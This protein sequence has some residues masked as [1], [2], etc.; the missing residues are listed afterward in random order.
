MRNSTL[1][2]V[3]VAMLLI[4]I[5]NVSV[6]Q[7][8]TFGQGD[9]DAPV[10][11]PASSV[12]PGDF[13]GDGIGDLAIGIPREDVTQVASTV[14]D[15]GAVNV[16]YGATG[17]L[18]ATG[19]QLLYQNMPGSPPAGV[20]ELLDTCEIDDVLP[21]ALAVGNFDGDAFSDLAIGVPLED[22]AFADCGAV[23]VVYGGAGGLSA[24]DQQ[25]INQDTLDILDSC[26]LNDWFGDSLAAG[27]FNNDGF[28][29]LAVGIPQEDVIAGT[30]T[31]TDA[32][33]VQVIYGSAAGLT[34][35]DQFVNQNSV[36]SYSIL[37]ASQASDNFGGTLAAGDYNNDGFFDLAI[38]V[39]GEDVGGT[40]SLQTDCGAVNVIYGASTGLS[41]AGN[42]IL[43]QDSELPVGSGVIEL[44][45]S[46]GGPDPGCETGDFLGNSLAAGDFD[47]DGFADLCIGVR[48]EDVGDKPIINSAGAVNCVY[49]SASRFT[50]VDDQFWSQDSPGILEASEVGD[51]FGWALAAGDFDND[52]NDDLAI[53][54][55]AEDVTHGGATVGDC[56]LTHVIYGSAGAG[57]ASADNQILF[58]NAAGPTQPGEVELLDTCEFGDGFSPNFG[59]SLLTGEF[60]GDGD[61]DLVIGM[62]FEEIRGYIWAGA[63]NVAFGSPS[64]LTGA[65]QFW[66]QDTSGI[67]DA[68]EEG[69]LYGWAVAGQVQTTSPVELIAPRSEETAPPAEDEIQD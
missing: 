7:D 11:P 1:L 35:T 59:F 46:G 12:L 10:V 62:F 5:L 45:D 54:V 67:R 34:S 31:I 16:I 68:A 53:G 57:L 64:G 23:H 15:C 14:E 41:G 33:A 19:N 63:V 9:N 13:N 38:G 25:F 24:A 42:Q 3:L 60:E 50:S 39:T 48:G 4:S 52:E 26:E 61:S 47:N 18:T 21:V 20:I 2:T 55:P 51:S 36:I 44:V 30:S 49:G 29:D 32:G 22:L 27:D 65:E 37:D 56:G 43:Y 6:I 69:D 66:N 28:A 17:G 40:S 8:T 58:Q